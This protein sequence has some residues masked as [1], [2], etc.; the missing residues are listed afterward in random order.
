MGTTAEKLQRILETKI[1]FKDLITEKGGVI[2]ETTTFHE[3]IDEARKLMDGGEVIVEEAKEYLPLPIGEVVEK[4]YINNSLT[5]EE[6]RGIIDQCDWNSDPSFMGYHFLFNNPDA[7][8]SLMLVDY[9]AFNNEI[10]A[11]ALVANQNGEYAWFWIDPALTRVNT[12]MGRGWINETFEYLGGNEVPIGLA[13]VATIE[14]TY[15]GVA[16]QLN[17]GT[18]NEQLSK[19]VNIGTKASKSPVPNSGYVDTIK[20]NTSLSCEEVDRI[21]SEANIPFAYY[22]AMYPIYSNY[23]RTTTSMI[24][25]CALLSGGLAQ[26][27]IIANIDNKA[28]V[29]YATPGLS[30]NEVIADEF[31]DPLPSGWDF[32]FNN[33]VVVNIDYNKENLPEGVVGAYNDKLVD[34]VYIGSEP[35]SAKLSGTYEATTVDITENGEVDL[36]TYWSSQQMPTT[37][38][39]NVEAIVNGEAI[40]VATEEELN[41]LMMEENIGKFYRYT[42]ETTN[43]YE[44]GSV[45]VVQDADNPI[46]E[47]E[48][49]NIATEEEMD[50][51]LVEENIG[52][53]FMYT[54]ETTDKYINNMVY[55]VQDSNNTVIDGPAIVKAE[56]TRSAIPREGYVDTVYFNTDL[57]PAEIDEIIRNANLTWNYSGAGEVLFVTEDYSK[58]IMIMNM[59]A[60]GAAGLTITNMKTNEFLYISQDLYDLM[61]SECPFV[62]WN[63]AYLTEYKVQANILPEL[64]SGENSLEIGMCNEALKDIIYIKSGFNYSKELSGEYQAIDVKLTNNQ[65]FELDSYLENKQIPV[66]INIDVAASGSLKSLLDY[67]KSTE[68]MFAHWPSVTEITSDHISFDATSNVTNMKEMFNGCSQL[69]S[70]P[71]FDTSNV[72]NFYSVFY[73]C[74]KLTEMP[75]FNLRN[76]IDLGWAFGYCSSLIEI[77]EFDVSSAVDLSRAFAYCSSL[78]RVVLSNLERATDIVR[79]FYWCTSL[80]TVVLSGISSFLYST[81]DMFE[82]CEN[83]TNLTIDTINSNLKVG[84]GESWG[85][86]LTLDSLINICQ[87][88][89]HQSDTNKLT[90]SD[91]SWEKLSSVYVRFIDPSI[92]EIPVGEKGEVEVCNSTD[93]RAMTISD[94]MTLK[95]WSI[96]TA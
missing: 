40:E 42:G 26:G 32:N 73:K 30:E 48:I 76:A 81:T 23:D 4:V 57:T 27:Y 21:I 16:Y 36:T 69:V 84:S 24:L 3:Y 8:L 78:K 63:P 70:I 41:S 64:V 56:E 88:C 17:V 55:I 52:K 80:E 6:V 5:N 7:G 34:L 77:P 54:G 75:S 62:G 68:S 74:S 59:E 2:T 49:K 58:N 18:F 43:N 94:Y 20:F 37:V 51:A 22:E 95:N 31:E 19:L 90:V 96:V 89:V 53:F 12:N 13:S 29:I 91:P 11:Y 14:D 79:L 87:A 93:D 25:D 66:K 39:V 85:T 72:T 92:T 44:Q 10:P 65:V 35:F 83:L 82:G 15:D 45:Y 28:T 86:K 33:E 9:T 1:G 71:L 47:E 46:I 61:P 67:T 38:N 50:A 60:Y